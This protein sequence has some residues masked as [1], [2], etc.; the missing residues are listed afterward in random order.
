V[1][2]R[3]KTDGEPSPEDRRKAELLERFRGMILRM[4]PPSMNRV[5]LAPDPQ[6]SFKTQAFLL[7]MSDDD[8]P[9]EQ[10][11]WL[12]ATD[13]C[14]CGTRA[15]EILD[16]FVWAA[17]AWG[18]AEKTDKVLRVVANAYSKPRR[19]HREFRRPQEQKD[20]EAIA[21]ME[22]REPLPSHEQQGPPEAALIP[23]RGPI[24]R[25]VAPDPV[26]TPRAEQA[27]GR[28]IAVDNLSDATERNRKVT[29]RQPGV[30]RCDATD[31]AHP[32]HPGLHEAST[33]EQ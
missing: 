29:S 6:W 32:R 13:V 10:Q 26:A 12:A 22:A 2:R 14:G 11:A 3:R 19:P 17:G 21:G 16:L 25:N 24:D 28:R 33:H 7:R 20:S 30:V 18:D 15:E 1:G 4:V 27:I 31:T 9:W 5:M 8:R 23:P